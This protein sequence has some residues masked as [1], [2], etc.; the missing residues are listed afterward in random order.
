M[1]TISSLGVGSGINAE[2]M[3]SQLMSVERQSLTSLQTKESGIKTKISAFGTISSLVDALSS[4]LSSMKSINSLAATKATSS[5]TDTLSATTSSAAKAG[6]YEINVTQLAKAQKTQIQVSDGDTNTTGSNE[7]VGS[8]K[9]KFTVEGN[10]AVEVDLSASPSATI[11][12]WRDAINAKNAG[13]TASIINTPTGAALTVTANDT[14][15]T[16]TFENT[17][18]TPSSLTGLADTGNNLVTAQKAKYTIDNIAFETASNTDSS[19]IS[20]VTLKLAKEGT[21]TLTVARDTSNIQSTVKDF[22]TAYNDLNSKIKSLTAYDATNKKGSTLTGDSTVRSLQNQLT[23]AMG[24]AY[25][26]GTYSHLSELGI[27]FQ[28]DGSLA[29]DSTKLDN[30]LAKDMSSV[31]SVIT[32]AS[33]ALY[34]KTYQMTKSGGA[35]TSKT[36]S[37]NSMVKE[38]TKREDAMNT[39]LATIEKRY[40]TMFT[41]LDST[42][43]GLSSTSSYLSQMLAKLG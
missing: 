7:L 23:T 42:V 2:A 22:V 35:I 37:L 24:Q 3:V 8:G 9:L 4:K 33:S 27:S 15:K 34:D 11:G 26:S 25:G 5:N 30:A 41:S 18:D 40:R 19:A 17:V 20:G 43:S 14:G 16:V 6:T 36:D 32:G 13:V 29:V 28:K 31:T 39:R 21:T 38:L 1:A 10:A 12:D